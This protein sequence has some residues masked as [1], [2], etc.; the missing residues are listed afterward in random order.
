MSIKLIAL[1]PPLDSLSDAF[2]SPYHVVNV[3]PFLA[4]LC[5]LPLPT[6]PPRLF[7]CLLAA[8]ILVTLA[9]QVLLVLAQ[10]FRRNDR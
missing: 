5:V 10:A 1:L 3:L 7:G 9:R 4:A 6:L 8:L 2:D